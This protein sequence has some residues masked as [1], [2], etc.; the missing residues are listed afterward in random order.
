MYEEFSDYSVQTKIERKILHWHNGLRW[1]KSQYK[2]LGFFFALKTNLGRE[3]NI[4]QLFLESIVGLCFVQY[5]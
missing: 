4:Q 2:V 3:H 5:Y 1:I